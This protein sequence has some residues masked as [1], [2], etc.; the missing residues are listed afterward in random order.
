MPGLC[1]EEF[2]VG[3]VFD[4]PWRRTVT[5]A[6]NVMFCGMTMNPARPHLDADYA[7]GTGFGRPLVNSLL[8]LGLMVGMSVNDTTFGTTLAN[9]GMTDVRFPK[10]VFH[11]DTLRITTSVLSLRPSASRPS[12]GIVEFEH[13]A[14]NRRN[15]VVGVRKRQALMAR[16]PA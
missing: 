12:R 1:F 4:H 2:T 15:E 16:R 6:D 7:A 5:E 9:L 14:H 10:P 3:Q 11:G 8:T 13:T